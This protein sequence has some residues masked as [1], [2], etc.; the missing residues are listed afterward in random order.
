MG[1]S[2]L[3]GATEHFMDKD[4]LATGQ[5]VISRDGDRSRD[6][7]RKYK[8]FVDGVES[9]SVRR[10]GSISIALAPGSHIVSLRI[11]WAGSP[12]I[13]V[14]IKPD[15]TEH[16]FCGPGG[17]ASDGLRAITRERRDSYIWLALEPRRPTGKPL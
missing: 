6:I 14:D 7:L 4:Q 1:L 10:N 3:S 8:I 11:D 12:E 5:L 2:K 13:R 9:G 17:R 15:Q 16:L